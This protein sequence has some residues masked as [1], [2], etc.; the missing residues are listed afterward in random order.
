M[1]V[2]GIEIVC[3]TPDCGAYC[4]VDQPTATKAREYAADRWGWA[5]RDGQDICD[6]CSR[7]NTPQARR[8]DR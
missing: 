8:G 3:D 4:S 1:T 5:H 2:R 7:G 6:P